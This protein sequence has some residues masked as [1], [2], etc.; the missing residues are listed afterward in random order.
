MATNQKIN[1]RE[2]LISS[3]ITAG[4]ALGAMAMG[5]GIAYPNAAQAKE[6]KFYQANCGTRQEGRSKILVAYESYLGST[7]GIAKAIGETFCQ[8]GAYVEVKLISQVNDLS[9]YQAAVIGSAVQKA[10]WMPKAIDFVRQNQDQLRQIKVA[11]FLSCLAMV[12][13]LGPASKETAK[14]RQV[15]ASYLNPVLKGVPA[16]KPVDSGLFAGVLDYDKL[17]FLEELIMRSKMDKRGIA[18]GDYRDFPAIRSWAAN[19]YPVLIRS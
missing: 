5:S 10:Q 15:A 8:L 3:T 14:A 1:R 6:K 12:K 4:G 9:Q 2:F 17:S 7:G 13:A 16:V 11:Y 19:L 18:P